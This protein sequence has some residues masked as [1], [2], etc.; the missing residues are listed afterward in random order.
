[1][2]GL[3]IG[4]NGNL[5][6][7]ETQQEG[8]RF[9]AADASSSN[10]I[11]LQCKD[12]LT[13]EQ[14]EELKRLHVTLLSYPAY[15]TYYCRYEPT[16]LDEIRALPYINYANIYRPEFVT[17]AGL[18]DKLEN[19]DEGH[20]PP[21]EKRYEVYISL[22][23]DHRNRLEQIRQKIIQVL[24]IDPELVNADAFILRAKLQSHE[25]ARVAGIDEVQRI[26]EIPR[27]ALSNN[28]ARVDL[29]LEY[30]IG[31]ANSRLVVGGGLGQIIAIADTG[32]DDQHE[33]LRG[34]VR[35]I[36][37]SRNTDARGHG[38]HVAAS[39]IGSGNSLEFGPIQGTAPFATVL[40]HVIVDNA[41]NITW[42]PLM[43]QRAYNRE[44]GAR[45]HSNS[46]NVSHA[47][48]FQQ[49]QYD[50]LAQDCDRM[51]ICLP[52][53]VILFSAGN[54][55]PFKNVTSDGEIE[56][57]AAAKNVIT[58]GACEST[59]PMTRNPLTY[60]Y[61]VAVPIPGYLALNLAGNRDQMALFSSRGP[62]KNTNGGPDDRR[63]KPDV[64]APGTV[65][66][67][68]KSSQLD[69][70]L[71]NILPGAIEAGVPNDGRWS[72]MNGTSMSTP[73]V[74]GCCATIRGR[75][76]L[77]CHNL[78]RIPSVLVKA[79]LI[80][81][82][83]WMVGTNQD[84]QGFGRVN[85]AKSMVCFSNHL[86]CGF[87]PKQE[88]DFARMQ[89]IQGQELK[90]RVPLPTA[91]PYPDGITPRFSL[92]VTMCY[93]DY[94]DQSGLVDH[95]SL[96][97]L[98]KTRLPDGTFPERYG[99]KLPGEPADN[100]NNVQKVI[101]D[102]ISAPAPFQHPDPFR[103]YVRVERL[104]RDAQFLHHFA[105]AWHVEE[106]SRGDAQ[107]DFWNER[108]PSTDARNRFMRKD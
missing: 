47:G 60:D 78:A 77:Q 102:G 79:I 29:N 49:R 45:I 87:W 96:K 81:G 88:S 83:K 15:N 6:D 11:L 37:G 30:I 86:G 75:I 40:S 44:Y 31:A 9:F 58:V 97:V 38:T 41:G 52:Q 63:I 50:G 14:K 92:T 89:M 67:S 16:E 66:Y 91:N 70:T 69:L 20:Q 64:V 3:E 23:E 51:A 26:E 18:K 98:Q 99:N 22:H 107:F 39:A 100:R 24:G 35:V 85:L 65:I 94:P 106:M 68:A 61:Y 7:A 33:A 27:L 48:I 101:W 46:Y 95:L 108:M 71:P 36:E 59:R 76:A 62:T 74:A 104:A 2:E 42:S 90:I 53:L 25:I 19:S 32:V 17:E 21:E 54:S 43:F 103:I 80:N 55:A 5:V 84:S 73:L 82:T 12:V 10:Y 56:S 8:G 105:L 93:L 34:R 28:H 1:M 4:L 72:Y 13:L 57:Q